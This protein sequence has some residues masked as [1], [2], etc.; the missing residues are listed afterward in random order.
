MKLG[1]WMFF[2][3]AGAGGGRMG[4]QR[5]MELGSVFFS[6]TR[7]FTAAGYVQPTSVGWVAAGLEG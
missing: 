1:F 4:R 5:W 6:H 2:S 3:V 7:R